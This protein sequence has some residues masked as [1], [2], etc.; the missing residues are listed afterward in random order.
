MGDFQIKKFGGTSVDK[1]NQVQGIIEGDAP[2]ANQVAVV[3]AFS[4]ETNNLIEIAKKLFATKDK[5]QLNHESICDLFKPRIEYAL[6]KAKGFLLEGKEALSTD[7]EAVLAKLK[8][9]LEEKVAG[10]ATEILPLLKKETLNEGEKTFVEDRIVGLGERFSASGLAEVF[11]VRSQIE[12]IYEGVDLADIFDNPEN[13]PRAHELAD[14]GGTY[15]KIVVQIREKLKGCFDRDNI[16]ILTGYAGFIP[17]GILNAIDRGYTDAMAALTARAVK[18]MNSENKPT[19]EIWKEIGGLQSSGIMSADPR[20]IPDA[21]PRKHIGFAQLAQLAGSG[22]MKAVNDKVMGI[23]WTDPV[24]IRIK[25]TNNPNDP[26]TLVLDDEKGLED[27]INHI[28]KNDQTMFT[29][30]SEKMAEKGMAKRIFECCT[31]LGI[32]VDAITTSQTSISFSIPAGN[33]NTEKLN[34]LLLA[35]GFAVEQPEEDMTLINLVGKGMAN[36]VGL[37]HYVTSVLAD[38]GINIEFDCGHPDQ[39]ITLVVAKKDAEKAV[40]ILHQELF[41]EELAQGSAQKTTPKTFSVPEEY[42]TKKLP[43]CIKGVS[44]KDQAMFTVSSFD[45]VDQP[46]VALK[47]FKIA[48]ELD[49]SVDAITTSTTSVSFSVDAGEKV[50]RLHARLALIQ[51]FRVDKQDEMAMI[52]LAGENMRKQVGILRDVTG[53]LAAHG[54]NIEF[55]CGNPDNDITVIVKKADAEKALAALKNALAA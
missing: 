13:I 14:R 29:V 4:G 23:L 7:E 25:N 20:L 21:I 8:A 34:E 28:A 53:I 47:I 26:G 9:H 51:G 43:A 18:G 17:G 41:K 31:K 33:K 39:N 40:K 42:K 3:S 19:L 55:D 22:R 54:V 11:T 6:E 48:D 45:L 38:N 15:E 36:Q 30:S 44:E 2:A 37:L 5:V 35:D 16:P 49:I 52:S 27:G 46:G 50:E 10:I 1:G 32:S 12:K 24:P